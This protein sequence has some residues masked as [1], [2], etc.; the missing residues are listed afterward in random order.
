MSFLFIILKCTQKE[1]EEEEEKRNKK[2][3]CYFI[4]AVRIARRSQAQ[5]ERGG[6]KTNR[7]E[8]RMRVKRREEREKT[9]T[10]KY[11]DK[12]VAKRERD[13]YTNTHTKYCI[14]SLLDDFH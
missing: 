1:E 11:T 8:I 10:F 6:E 2:T 12:H 5:Y 13:I 4:S 7:Q 14:S 3:R 9:L